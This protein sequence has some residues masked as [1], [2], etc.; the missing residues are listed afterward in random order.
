LPNP[1][2]LLSSITA[3]ELT[4]YNLLCNLDISKACGED[5]ISNV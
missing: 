5:G 1:T 3:S 2:C 4:V